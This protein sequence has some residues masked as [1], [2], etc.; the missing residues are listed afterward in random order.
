MTCVGLALFQLSALLTI[1][2]RC[3]SVG[4]V[5]NCV[6]C[7]LTV[8]PNNQP[9]KVTEHIP[10]V[11]HIQP[12]PVTL[13]SELALAMAS[14][15]HFSTMLVHI[16]VNAVVISHPDVYPPPDQVCSR[17]PVPL[18][19][20]TVSNEPSQT[21]STACLISAVGRGTRWS[22]HER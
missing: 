2:R 13:M 8:P 20:T 10:A 16:Q 15:T 17:A 5:R 18:S 1:C 7:L 6:E 9:N 19:Q 3:V 14:I 22:L 11:L 12:P 4:R 21:A